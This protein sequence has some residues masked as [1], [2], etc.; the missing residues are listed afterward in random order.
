MSRRGARRVILAIALLLPGAVLGAPSASAQ[1]AP[2]GD[3]AVTVSGE[4]EFENLEVTVSQ[5]KNLINQTV[6]VSWTGGAPTVGTATANF[7]QIMQC[8][9][10][11]LA[12]GPDRTQCQFGAIPSGPPL[13]GAW[14]RIRQVNPLDP[15]ERLTPGPDG[16]RHVPF[17]PAGQP[18]RP[19]NLVTEST[20]EFYDAQVTNEVPIATTRPNGTGQVDFEIQTV[21]ESAGLGCGQPVEVN[22]TTAGRPCW[23]VI[24]PRGT[25]E[26][27][28]SPVVDSAGNGPGLMTSPLAQTNWDKKIAVR[29]DFLPQG[30]PCPIGTP[31]RRLTGH[32]LVVD[33][34]SRWQPALC[35]NGGA[36]YGLTQLSDDL[37]RSQLL[38]ASDPGL[39]LISN[40]VSPDQLL[41]NRPLVYAPVTVSGLAFAFNLVANPPGITG[42]NDPRLDAAGQPLTEMKLT[43]RLVAKLL[44][45][46]YRGAITGGGLAVPGG[47]G[48]PAQPARLQSNP[49]G[50][51]NDPEFLDLNSGYRDLLPDNLHV[52]ALVQL[53][54]SD[55][56]G[57]L[58]DWV[59][60]DPD[61][62]AFIDGSPDREMVVNEA[63]KGLRP[64]LYTYPRNDQ[65]C[66]PVPVSKP[67]GNG[68]SMVS[69]FCTG[70]EHQFS[71]DMHE[72]GRAAS[73]GDTLG[74]DPTNP[75]VAPDGTV[76]F[77]KKQRQPVTARALIAVVDVA[78]ADRYQMPTAKL[79]NAAGEFVAPD[80]AGLRAG[81]DAM[82]PS[83][84]QGVL[85]PDP[86]TRNAAAYPLTSLSYAA[87]S[88]PALTEDAGRDY[89]AFLRY[90][91]GAG[92]QP[93][94][95]PG[96]LPPGYVPLPE[97][98]R[99]QAL[100][101]ATII[102]TQAGKSIEP[103][104]APPPAASSQG[105]TAPVPDLS[106][107]AAPDP[108]LPGDTLPNAAPAPAP[109]P[110][111]VVPPGAAPPPAVTQKP[112]TEVRR[113][114]ATVIAA[115][116]GLLVALLI[117]GALAAGLAPIV[118]RLGA[119]TRATPDKEVM[120]TGP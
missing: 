19:T 81:L 94:L 110:P 9:G 83:A 33:A 87:T 48:I 71:N 93:G 10:D 56:T 67:G 100:A 1:D 117:S 95:L 30:R 79:R 42:N 26:T 64:P 23:L 35:A 62:R 36:L 103:P 116:G 97:P 84:V 16:G 27:D 113:T 120:P 73:R 13:S 76:T 109:A 28:G 31:E 41:P 101:V 65:G 92:Q 38:E 78:T 43:P 6:K 59:L 90:A 106:G 66:R 80:G 58:W 25:K 34:V 29:L 17:W 3:S 40:P 105:M 51:T 119:P 7:L 15:A 111:A 8:W 69:P 115:M 49:A 77:A 18:E 104:A 82:K 85:Q 74:R 46:S 86:L 52:D 107:P 63:N 22:G 96:Q 102:E 114:P 54:T 37:T 89:A 21:R 70:D 55:L 60:A 118:H 88:P 11:D 108:S 39:A 2:A 14:V 5:T 72:S 45:Q 99:Q 112:V 91:V 20:S 75:S 47:Q 98:L 4:G 12:A 68:E 50:L 32:E 44:T 24:V 61:A 53:G 57:L